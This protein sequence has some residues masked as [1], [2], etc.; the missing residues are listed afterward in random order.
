[1]RACALRLRPMQVLEPAQA[2]AYRDVTLAQY[3]E[4]NRY[5]DAFSRHYL[6]PM[7]AAVWSVPNA[8]VL[9]FPVQMLVRFWV[10]HH[11]LDLTQRPKWR[12]VKGRS[13]NYVNAVLA[14][15]QGQATKAEGGKGW[16]CAT[17]ARTT[18]TLLL[19]CF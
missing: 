13:V 14:G 2:A 18:R 11:L 7:C 3:L 8:Q 12:V 10:N 1:M 19:P 16:W 5:S 17:D 15:E 4:R 6:L 9:E